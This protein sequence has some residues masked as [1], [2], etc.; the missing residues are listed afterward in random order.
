MVKD[1]DFQD[2]KIVGEKVHQQLMDSGLSPSVRS[3]LKRAAILYTEFL[4]SLG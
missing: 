1:L 4:R 2:E 3:Q